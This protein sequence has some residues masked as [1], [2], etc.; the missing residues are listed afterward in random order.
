M[1]KK[2]CI[3]HELCVKDGPRGPPGPRG[4]Q[5]PIGGIPSGFSGNTNPIGIIILTNN[6]PTGT[7][8]GSTTITSG[9]TGYIWGTTSA[10]FSNVD[11]NRYGL[12]LYLVINEKIGNLTS[13]V[14]P[15]INNGNTG[16]LNMTSQQRT[17]LM[18]GPTGTTIKA[19]A[20]TDISSNG[21]VS[22]INCDIFGLGN[23]S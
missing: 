6:G 8:I 4:I 5:G 1:T 21:N 15:P 11:T 17:S 13:G 2:H 19:F 7:S 23:L 9:I 20:Y 14:I 18:I 10:S 12:K 16:Y 3:R 22:C